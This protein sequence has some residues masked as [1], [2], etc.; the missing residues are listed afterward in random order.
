MPSWHFL[1][2]EGGVVLLSPAVT[3][4]LKVVA[5]MVLEAHCVINVY[6]LHSDFALLFFFLSFQAAVRDVHIN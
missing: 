4:N 5:V 3:L 1:Q 6:H 2:Q